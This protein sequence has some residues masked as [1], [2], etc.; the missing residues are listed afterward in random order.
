[1]NAVIG[2]FQAIGGSH[3]QRDLF[4]QEWIDCA[5][6]AN[7]PD[8][9]IATLRERA[10]TRPAVPWGWRLLARAQRLDGQDRA[11]RASEEK[12]ARAADALKE[13]LTEKN[14]T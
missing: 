6:A 9:V 4:V 12:A 1:M 2:D 5:L 8:M 13:S 3:A 7:R 11:A 14:L 10:E